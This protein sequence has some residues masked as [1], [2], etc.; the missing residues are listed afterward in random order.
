MKT[1]ARIRKR[2]QD[3]NHKK[4]YITILIP[5]NSKEST[6]KYLLKKF[7]CECECK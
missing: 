5:I 3:M 1:K 6:I 4:G 7:S 2:K